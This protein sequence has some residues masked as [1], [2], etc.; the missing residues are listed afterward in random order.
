MQL[1]TLVAILAPVLGTVHAGCYSGGESWGSEK[2]KATSAAVQVC[3]TTVAGDFTGGQLKSACRQLTD[4]KRVEF[5]VQWKG[6]GNAFIS[7]D[8]CVLR[9]TNEIGGCSNGGESDI[10]QWF[11]RSDPNAGTC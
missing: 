2:G 1:I 6:S 7:D 10:G 5:V 8:E 9:L 11:F 4:T 3:D